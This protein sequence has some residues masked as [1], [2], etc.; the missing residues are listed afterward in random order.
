MRQSGARK[1]AQGAGLSRPP[2]RN[3][4]RKSSGRMTSCSRRG[5]SDRLAKE[6]PS[7]RACANRHR[8]PARRS[9]VIHPSAAHCA[10]GRPPPQ[11][12]NRTW[13]M[14]PW[15][16][17]DR[18]P[19]PSRRRAPAD[20]QGTRVRHQ[21]RRRGTDDVA[22]QRLGGGAGDAGGGGAEPANEAENPDRRPRHGLYAARGA[23]SVRT[24]G[25][26]SSRSS[27]PLSCS[28]PGGRWRSSLAGRSTIRE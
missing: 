22:A 16:E 2:S 13:L 7:F 12:R 21:D 28:G 5:V 27:F 8:G 14:I 24:R 4:R 20:A 10:N 9:A 1:K 19:L 3:R 11:D 18:T 6:R 15:I 25:A 23:G 26:S 17:L